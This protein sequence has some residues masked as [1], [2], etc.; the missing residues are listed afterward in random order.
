MQDACKSCGVAPVSGG[1]GGMLQG[2]VLLACVLVGPYASYGKP[3]LARIRHSFHVWGSSSWPK[4]FLS[5][6]SYLLP[7]TSTLLF[8][9]TFVHVID[10][11]PSSC[12]YHLGKVLHWVTA[13]VIDF[14]NWA[15]Y[16]F[17]GTKPGLADD[18]GFSTPL[19]PACFFLTTETS[20]YRYVS[21]KSFDIRPPAP[22]Y[23]PSRCYRL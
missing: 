7:P 8:P 4:V 6:T 21:P 10:D 13:F 11:L 20:S 9:S 15:L 19:P 16:C 5:P 22:L 2:P 12:R 17:A 18:R 23:R 1:G 3:I 14:H